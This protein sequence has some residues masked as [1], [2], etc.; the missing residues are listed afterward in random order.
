MSSTWL[1]FN[2]AIKKQG[3]NRKQFLP[4]RSRFQPFAAWYAFIM[5]TCVLGISGYTLFLPGNFEVDQFI[6]A[7]KFPPGP[8]PRLP[9]MRVADPLSSSRGFTEYAWDLIRVLPHS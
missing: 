4:Y 9:S 1:R 2:N 5:S 7:C 3:I 8:Y 6:F